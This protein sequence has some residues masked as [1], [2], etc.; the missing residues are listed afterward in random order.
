MLE[1]QVR[2]PYITSHALCI[3]M[4]PDTAPI[5]KFGHWAGHSIRIGEARNA[6]RVFVGSLLECIS[7]E[8]KKMRDVYC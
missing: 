8:T 2:E 7:W 5:L 6:F 1:L 3:V 4:S